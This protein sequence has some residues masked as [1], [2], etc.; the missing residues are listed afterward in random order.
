[1]RKDKGMTLVEVVVALTLLM[2]GM[3]FVLSNNKT[4][5][6][7]KAQHELRQEMFFY[8]AGQVEAYLEQGA[9]VPED[10]NGI[11]VDNPPVVTPVSDPLVNGYL[12]M[13]TITV[14]STNSNI[15]PV[16]IRTL[17]GKT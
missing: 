13:V 11:S 6:K 5:F 8:A 2:I 7:Y 4:V 16:V 9:I 10:L 14:R 12:E 17:R 15:D 1:M 3:G